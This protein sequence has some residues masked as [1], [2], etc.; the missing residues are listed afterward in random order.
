MTEKPLLRWLMLNVSLLLLPV[1]II[2][3][4]IYYIA[5]LQNIERMRAFEIEAAELLESLRF[6]SGTEKY[7]CSSLAGLFEANPSPEK[8]KEAVEKFA[9]D[10]SLNLQF[11]INNADGSIFYSSFPVEQLRGDAAAAHSALQIIKRKGYPGGERGIPPDVYANLRLLYGPHF[12]PRYFNRCFTGKNIALRRG[13]ADTGKPLLWINVNENT[14]LSVFFPAAVIDSYCG[15]KYYASQ[16]RDKLIT[17]FIRNGVVSCH[18]QLLSQAVSR[19]AGNLHKSLSSIVRLPDHYMLLNYIDATMMVFCAVKADHLEKMRFS[20]ITAVFILLLLLG[21]SYFAIMSYLV[22]VRGKVLS[23]SLKLQLLILFVSSNA[24]AGFVLYTIGSDY[25]QQYRSGLLSTAYNDG[26]AY[27]QSIDE[28]FSNEFTVQKGRLDNHLSAFRRGLKKRGVSRQVV[29]KFIKPQSPSP[30]AFFLVASST[31]IVAGDRGILKDEKVHEGFSLRFK[32]D[33]L[34]INTM[35][36]MFKIGTFVLASLNKQTISSRA[37]TE[38]EMITETLTQQSPADLMRKFAD[39]GSFSEWGIGEKMHP[40]YVNLLQLFDNKLYDYMLL[41][42]WDADDLELEFVRRVFLNLSRNELGLQVMIVD[43]KFLHGYPK[44]IL[45]NTRLRNFALKLRDRSVTRPE[46]CDMGGRELLMLGHKCVAMKNIR[47]LGLYP[48]EKIDS[49]VSE[50]SQLLVLLA[51]VSLLISVSMSLFVAGSILRPLGE[52][53]AG[54]AALNER[55][56]AWRV[57]D[58]GGDEFGHLAAIFNETLVD[59][60]EL[61]VASQV[62]EKLLTQL[63]EP[64]SVGCLRVFCQIRANS[65][66]S[67]DYFD[68]IDIDESQTA[69]IFGRVMERGVAGSLVLAFVKSATMQIQNLSHRPELLVAALNSLLASSSGNSSNKTMQIQ[70]LLLHTDG[71]IEMAG[72][73]V[74]FMAVFDCACGQLKSVRHDSGE[75]GNTPDKSFELSGLALEPGQILI[76]STGAG[77]FVENF[78]ERV[79]ACRIDEVDQIYQTILDCCVRS[80]QEVASFLIITRV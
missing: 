60:E 78:S 16:P 74:P 14:G 65:G 49:Q 9:A 42:L 39:Q 79:S 35:K 77:E 13:H 38:A 26:M 75:I 11:F 33:K 17:G 12:F 1:L 32:E 25:L 66:Y 36:A 80:G 63:T 34:R 7:L 70:N 47:L 4:G 6:Y 73:G 31:G 19:E 45:A 40:T 28:L 52:L 48:I 27:L 54:V 5:S 64:R 29:Q 55:N 59:L 56:F 22:V 53:Q 61:H 43:E 51:F 68:L 67:G 76:L 57:P 24:M 30:Y 72:A 58:L 8:L 2:L 21:L 69:I 15:L 50:K 71:K 23:L 37:G 20:T 41:Y 18:D 3:A 62:Q 44:E 10:H 46:R